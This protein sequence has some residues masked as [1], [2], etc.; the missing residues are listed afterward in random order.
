MMRASRTRTAA[1]MVGGS[2]SAI[3]PFPAAGRRARDA[4]G[5]ADNR[6]GED[7]PLVVTNQSMIDASHYKI[8]SGAIPGGQSEAGRRGG[9]REEAPGICQASPAGAEGIAGQRTGKGL[10]PQVTSILLLL[11]W[12]ARARKRPSSPRPCNG[13]RAAC[14]RMACEMVTPFSA[15]LAPDNRKR[16]EKMRNSA[17]QGLRGIPPS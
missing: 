11:A 12:S 5:A 9:A 17:V 10:G 1:A 6:P 7:F 15:A 8:S 16:M 3:V 2:R 14:S 4:G 13:P